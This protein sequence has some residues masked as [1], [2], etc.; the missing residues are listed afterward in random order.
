MQESNKKIITKLNKLPSDNYFRFEGYY[1]REL[2]LWNDKTGT[3]R[4]TGSEESF[5]WDYFVE[6]IKV[7]KR[8]SMII[9]LTSL[10]KAFKDNVSYPL[11][12]GYITQL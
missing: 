12:D 4:I 11:G 9:S 3:I 2:G 1:L 6:D 8:G 5:D 10:L 7:L